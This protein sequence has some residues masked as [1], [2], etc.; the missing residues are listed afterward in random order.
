MPHQWGPLL[1]GPTP[2]GAAR[3]PNHNIRERSRCQR[4][5]TVQTRRRG[6]QA[7]IAV[8]NAG[9]DSR[10]L[11]DL[12]VPVARRPSTGRRPRFHV[13]RSGRPRF[14]RA[15]ASPRRWA[16]AEQRDASTPPGELYV[17]PRFR[18][19]RRLFSWSARCAGLD[20]RD[21]VR[22]RS[23]RRPPRHWV[24]TFER[25]DTGADCTVRAHRSGESGAPR[26]PASS[27]SQPCSSR[28]PRGSAGGP[29]SD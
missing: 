18:G 29:A 26:S 19:R 25:A 12:A 23:H 21:A 24:A 20:Q 10:G 1:Q 28:R 5:S 15:T 6:A 7:R 27:R 14:V 17:S 2:G 22:A 3:T 11:P 8:G 13:V 9:A 16:A 4:A